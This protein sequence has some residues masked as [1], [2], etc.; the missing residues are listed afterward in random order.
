MSLVARNKSP[1]LDPEPLMSWDL[2]L[3]ILDSIIGRD[4]NVM[5]SIVFP[6]SWRKVVNPVLNEFME[7]C[8]QVFE[9]RNITCPG[10]DRLVEETYHDPWFPLE[11]VYY[12][13]Q[14]YTCRNCLKHFCYDCEDNNG[15]GLLRYCNHCEKD[16]C[17]ECAQMEE[18]GECNNDYCKN[19]KS[20]E[21]CSGCQRNYCKEC[22]SIE[23]CGD[24]GYFHCGDCDASHHPCMIISSLT[25][26]TGH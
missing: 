4:D 17:G 1:V 12:G 2:V 23:N 21:K 15:K 3:P 19:C 20:I 14:G 6:K 9:R 25:N 24:C 10:C 18:C 22:K 7:R 5:R 13:V 8:N 26:A 16:Y 11:R